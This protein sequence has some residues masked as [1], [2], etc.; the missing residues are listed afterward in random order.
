MT[1]DLSI[2]E[3]NIQFLEPFLVHPGLLHWDAGPKVPDLVKKVLEALNVMKENPS[4]VT[5]RLLSSVVYDKDSPLPEKERFMAHSVAVATITRDLVEKISGTY[6]DLSL[7]SPQHAYALGLLHDFSAA[8]SLWRNGIPPED[9]ELT[10]YF[11]CKHLGVQ[12]LSDHSA[13]HGAY[14]EILEMIYQGEGFSRVQEYQS[15]TRT[16]RDAANPYNFL[17]VRQEFSSFLEGKDNL[18]LMVVTIADFL[19][20]RSGNVD[21]SDREALFSVRTGDI[22]ERYYYHPL[23]QGDAVS[24]FG[25][26]LMQRGGLERIKKYKNIISSLLDGTAEEEL[27]ASFRRRA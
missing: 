2:K 12:A 10:L 1:L 13:M 24:A 22:L 26:A 3:E 27:I 9:K 7:P 8:Y 23:R 5:P 6:N 4:L 16:L 21:I 11:H 20:N 14:F 25:L 19:D 17:G 15:W 18:P